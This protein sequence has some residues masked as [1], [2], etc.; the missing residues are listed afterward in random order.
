MS[1]FGAPI[2]IAIHSRVLVRGV[3]SENYLQLRK[4]CDS[5]RRDRI[6]RSISVVRKF[7]SFLVPANG[8]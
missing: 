7:T 2:I 3:G 8:G 4:D 5:G 6:I 1:M